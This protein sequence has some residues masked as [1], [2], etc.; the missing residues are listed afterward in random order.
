LA[1]NIIAN[2]SFADERVE[3]DTRLLLFIL[4]LYQRKAQY[5]QNNA[6]GL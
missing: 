5:N 1:G 6:A 4:K 3:R 2:I